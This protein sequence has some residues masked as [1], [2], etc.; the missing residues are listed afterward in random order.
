M[1]VQFERTPV[2]VAGGARIAGCGCIAFVQRSEDL[3][4]LVPAPSGGSDDTL[5]PVTR[6]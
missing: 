3:Y 5:S 4:L 1:R 2:A 6:P